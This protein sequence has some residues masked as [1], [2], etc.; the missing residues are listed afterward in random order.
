M[1]E[2]INLIQ[3]YHFASL[4]PDAQH[5][6]AAAQ[7]RSQECSAGIDALYEKRRNALIEE[8]H[9]IGWNVVAPQLNLF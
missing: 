6:A 7:S 3:D 1:I 5:A 4:L 8:C 9:R 2:A